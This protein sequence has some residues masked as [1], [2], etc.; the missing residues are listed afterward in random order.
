MTHIDDGTLVTFLRERA[1]DAVPAPGLDL[2]AVLASSRRKRALIRGA[3]TAI[4]LV[5][6]GVVVVGVAD[7][8]SYTHLTLPTIYSV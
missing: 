3:R 5:V 4:A 6:A 2:G 8:V 1:L 7:P